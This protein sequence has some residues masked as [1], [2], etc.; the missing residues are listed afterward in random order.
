MRRAGIIDRRGAS[1]RP[2]APVSA[3]SAFDPL[4]TD[5]VL[6]LDML[7]P[8]SYTIVGGNTISDWTCL[9]SG[10]QYTTPGSDCPYEDT[11]LNGKP[12]CHPTT[13][14]HRL[15]GT[16]ATVLSLMSSSGSNPSVII[17]AAT[18]YYVAAYDAADPVLAAGAVFSVANSA[19]GNNRRYFGQS[20]TGA[21][22][23]QSASINNTPTLITTVSAGG[24]NTNV[25]VGCWNWTAAPS[26][27]LSHTV[28]D[29]A[30]IT[31]AAHDPTE[32]GTVTFSPNRVGIFVVPDNAEDSPLVGR[33]S[34]ILLVSGRDDAA[35]QTARVA[36]LQARWA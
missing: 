15:I 1:P 8:S 28:D 17:P 31:D 30:V 4:V 11:G 26:S 34:Q 5:V 10:H 7:T 24:D 3:G 36:A 6:N 27:V 21:G 13:T 16:Q 9:I 14:A 35:T 19:N 29:V 20:N 18:L 12:T 22:R 25:H 23:Y 2:P 33:C 32:A